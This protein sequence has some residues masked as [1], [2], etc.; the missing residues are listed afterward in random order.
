MRVRIKRKGPVFA[1]IGD[2]ALVVT[3]GTDADREVLLRARVTAAALKRLLRPAVLDAVPAYGSVAVFYDPARVTAGPGT[4]FERMCRQIGPYCPSA[5]SAAGRRLRRLS[6]AGRRIRRLSLAGRRIEIPVCY[7]G[8]FGPDMDAVA[9]RSGLS[10][11]DVAAMFGDAEY[12]VQ[13]I[14]FS[15]G[16]PYLAGLPRKLHTPRKDTPRESVPA[17]SV[18][19]GGGQAGVYPIATPGGWNLIG[20]TPLRLFRVEETPP[21]LLKTGDR[22]TFKAITPEEFAAWK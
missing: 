13:A 14:G 11:K 18:G 1:P 5:P 9:A 15:P 21:A 10:P 20:R 3:L 19:I 22:V 7:G 2:S 16:F 17:G 12:L 4:P 8:E 6:L